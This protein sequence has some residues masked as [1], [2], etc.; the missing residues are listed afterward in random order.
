MEGRARLNGI[1]LRMSH[2]LPV[3]DTHTNRQCGQRDR[4]CRASHPGNPSPKGSFGASTVGNVVWNF[5]LPLFLSSMD[6]GVCIRWWRLVSGSGNVD[7]GSSV[8][9]VG[10]GCKSGG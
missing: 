8:Q 1:T 2:S 3:V 7:S 4:D 9:V 6:C 10:L 5:S